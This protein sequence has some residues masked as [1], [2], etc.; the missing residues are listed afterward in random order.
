VGPPPAALSALIRSDA[1]R[2]ATV[3]QKARIQAD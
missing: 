3:I 1:E 2:W